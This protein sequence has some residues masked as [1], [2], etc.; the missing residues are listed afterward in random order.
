ML[1]NIIKEE[2]DKFISENQGY[3][4]MTIIDVAKITA[5]FTGYGDQVKMVNSF[6]T[7]FQNA[8]K[9][10]GDNGVIQLFKESTQHDIFIIRAGR[11]SFTPQITPED[12]NWK[13]FYESVIADLPV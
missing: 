1:L 12:H 9:K 13:T 3:D 10:D 7:M 4:N 6:I 2:I 5:D 11:Y 8:Y